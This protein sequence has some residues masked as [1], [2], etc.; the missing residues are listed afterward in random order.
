MLCQEVSDPYVNRHE[1]RKKTREWLLEQDTGDGV[2]DADPETWGISPEAEAAQEAMM[3]RGS[4]VG[5][6]T[7]ETAHQPGGDG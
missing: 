4:M 7:A 2:P 6:D 5:D 3:R 1:V